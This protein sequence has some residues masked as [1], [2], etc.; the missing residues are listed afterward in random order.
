MNN[1]P[2]TARETMMARKIQPIIS[3]GVKDDPALA[4]DVAEAELVDMID[5]K[6]SHFLGRR[7][8]QNPYIREKSTTGRQ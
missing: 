6:E 1:N 2:P 3:L 7:R 5:C 8:A 4:L